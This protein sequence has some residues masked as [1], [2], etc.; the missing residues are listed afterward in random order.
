MNLYK[1]PGRNIFDSSEI[2][3]NKFLAMGSR[4]ITVTENYRRGCTFDNKITLIKCR[5]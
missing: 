2:H 4:T 3:E 5:S 1:Y